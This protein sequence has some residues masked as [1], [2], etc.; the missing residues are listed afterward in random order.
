MNSNDQYLTLTLNTSYFIKYRVRL[1]ALHCNYPVTKK[2]SC[3]E[4]Q[5]ALRFF[6]LVHQRLTCIGLV[7]IN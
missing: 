6:F 4:K 2:F 5:F 1:I 7:S 3:S